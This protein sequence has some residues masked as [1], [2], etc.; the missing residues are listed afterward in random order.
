VFLGISSKKQPLIFMIIDQSSLPCN[1]W[2]RVVKSVFLDL[3]TE[4]PHRNFLGLSVGEWKTH[5][6][7]NVIK[8]CLITILC[9][10]FPCTNFQGDHTKSYV[11]FLAMYNCTCRHIVC[12]ELIPHVDWIW[13]YRVDAYRLCSNFQEK[14][15]TPGHWL[16]IHN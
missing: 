16:C 2:G 1:T 9:T 7:C 11:I 10:S 13:K 6:L 8:F 3:T 14:I 12:V 15:F 4:V 5:V